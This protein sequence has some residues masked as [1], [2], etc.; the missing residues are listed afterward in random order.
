M[1]PRKRSAVETKPDEVLSPLKPKSPAKGGKAVAGKVAPN[2][3]K[4]PAKAKSLAKPRKPKAANKAAVKPQAEMKAPVKFQKHFIG[5][6]RTMFLSKVPDKDIAEVIGID[7]ETMEWWKE[8][9]PDFGDAFRPDP[10]NYG[11]RPSEW[12]DRNIAIAMTLAELG[13]TDLEISQAFEV[14]IRTIHRWKLEHPEFRA[15]LEL[16]KEAADKKVEDSLF[17]RATGYSFDSEKIVV[18]EG[19]AQRVEIIEHVPPDVKAGMWWLQNRRPGIWRDVRHIK[20]DVE[21]DSALG[22][23][24]QK[25]GGRAISPV[26]QDGPANSAIGTQGKAFT[27]VDDEQDPNVRKP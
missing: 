7:A 13:A 16:G 26:D 8:E 4:A 17:K 22:S 21:K 6:A 25:V 24:L 2:S 18:I 5:L 12:D 27:P 19:E 1:A 15:A 23:F 3:T 10:R 9:H 14:S 11:G 20:H